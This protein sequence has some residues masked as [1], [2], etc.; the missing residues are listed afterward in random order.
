M[1]QA[2]AEFSDMV[3]VTSDNPRSEDPEDIIADIV[4][5]IPD[6]CGCVIEPDRRNAIEYALVRAG[7]DDIVL[8]AGKGH[9]AYQEIKGRQHHFDDREVIAAV[10]N[11]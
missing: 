11:K 9:E 1:A 6:D 3:V 7:A 5:G 2:A 8:V 10:I 4:A